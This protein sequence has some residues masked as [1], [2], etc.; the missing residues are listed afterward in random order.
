M[1]AIG[2]LKH[3]VK[4]DSGVANMGMGKGKVEHMLDF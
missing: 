3:N 1:I 2:Y 4:K